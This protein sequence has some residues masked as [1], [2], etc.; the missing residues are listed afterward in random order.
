MDRLDTIDRIPPGSIVQLGHCWYLLIAVT[1]DPYPDQ[2]ARLRLDLADPDSGL[3]DIDW[4]PG[5]GA[6]LHYDPPA[7]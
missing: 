3:P 6:I 2:P 1:P 7:A 4:V 5:P